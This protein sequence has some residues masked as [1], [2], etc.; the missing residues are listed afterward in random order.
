[1]DGYFVEGYF[2]GSG[3]GALLS[4]LSSYII[5]G[6]LLPDLGLGGSLLGSGGSGRKRADLCLNDDCGGRCGLDC[7]DGLDGG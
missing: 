5:G 3:G 4:S 2:C 6:G 7:L 1:M